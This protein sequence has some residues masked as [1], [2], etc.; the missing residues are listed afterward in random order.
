MLKSDEKKRT[1]SQADMFQ[2]FAELFKMGMNM[3]QGQELSPDAQ[4]LLDAGME[5]ASKGKKGD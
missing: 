3:Q 1:E 4:R 5:A 2:T